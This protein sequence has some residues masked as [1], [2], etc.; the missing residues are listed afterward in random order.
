MNTINRTYAGKA[1]FGLMLGWVVTRIGFGDFGELN[2][3]FTFGNL[4]FGMGPM[5]MFLSFAG[6]VALALVAFQTVLRHKN[7][8]PKIHKGVVPGAVMFGTGWAISGGCPAIPV[9]QV[10]SGYLP[11]L[12]TVAGVLIGVYLCRQVNARWLHLDGGSCSR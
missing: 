11:A 9:I 3:M 8:A 12:V 6:G 5:R 1:V 4:K 10:A 2:N 7:I